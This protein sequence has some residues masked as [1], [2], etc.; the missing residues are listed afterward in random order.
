MKKYYCVFCMLI[1]TCFLTSAVTVSVA[2]PAPGFSYLDINN[3]SALFRAAGPHFFYDKAAYEV[4]K[5][6][7][8]TSIFSNSVWIGGKDASGNLHFAGERYRQGPFAA[9][10]NTKPDFYAGP[11]MDSVNYSLIQDSVWNYIW[12]L[13]KTDIDYH[14]A[15]Y[16]QSGYQPI[17]DILTWPGNGD[18]LKGQAWQLAPFSDRNNDGIYD[19]YDGDYPS[20]R[21]D[22]ALFFIFNDDRGPHLESLGE[23][24][25]IEFHGMAYAFDMPE[26][27]AMKNT[28]FLNYKIFNRSQKTYDSTYIGIFTDIDLGYAYDDYIGCDVERNMYYGYNGKSVDGSGQPE[29]YGANPPTQAVVFLAGPYMDNDGIDNPRFDNAGNQLCDYSVNGIN[30][31]DSVVDNE[32]LGMTGFMYH[33]NSISGV[34]WY[35][36]DPMYAVDYYRFLRGIWRDGQPMTYG[37]NGHP[38]AGGYGPIC[39]FMFPGES[40]TIN[41][42][43][44]CIAPNPVLWNEITANNNPSDRRGVGSS[45]PFT[46]NQGAVQEIDL[47]FVWARD[48]SSNTAGG[49]VI[50]LRSMVD[51]VNKAFVTNQLS[52]GNSFLGITDPVVN[53][54]EK[55]NIY[56]NP[57]SQ[58]L[59]LEFSHFLAVASIDLTNAKGQVLKSY[60]I[61]GKINSFKMD[62]SDV[63]SGF[64]IIKVMT[65]DTAITRKVLINR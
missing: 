30:F 36:Q 8:K 20:I 45:G 9:P 7:G 2:Q 63:A 49:S 10:A 57:A 40:D 18:T 54:N 58:S 6:S 22:Q 11:I 34:P 59:T 13:K 17:P 65:S 32:R 35:M 52:N 41:W 14:L 39:R 29:A 16:A 33:N 27:S 55:L 23:K 19:P 42:G 46:F 1:F 25:R 51:Q 43:T 38:D 64:Y 28:V 44:G 37:G 61:T 31:G 60:S 12:N 24:L 62:V 53:S 56:P 3:V 15:H 21:G 48:Y 4:P 50:K 47:S 26:D 5:G